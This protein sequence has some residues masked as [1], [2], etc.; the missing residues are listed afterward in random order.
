MRVSDKDMPGVSGAAR[1]A[2]VMGWPVSHS[3]SPRLHG[4]W[5]RRYGVDGAY[6][7]LAVEPRHLEQALRALPALGF[8][9]VNVTVPHKEAVLAIVD[10]ADDLARR[11]GAVN[12]VVVAEDGRLIGRNTDAFGFLENLRQQA[13]DFDP[14]AAPVLILGA[15]GAARAVAAGLLDA[16]TPEVMICNRSIG[17]AEIL[18]RA[19]D[20][21]RVSAL[22]WT[23]RGRAVATAGLIVNSTSLGMTG[24]PDLDL[25]LTMARADAVVADIV[26]TPLRTKTLRQA[27]A[28]GLTAVDGLGMLIHQARPGFAAWFG[29]DPDPEPELRAM[30]LR[31]LGEPVS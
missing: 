2:G 13:P 14:V 22:P 23:E 25:D 4:F 7:P 17:R 28:R 9:G 11:I 3:R 31:D 5:L 30:L 19:L 20:P 1:L 21:T 26:Y 16:G 18:V 6:L 27:A 10:E 12:T 29:I 8:R 24:N 15:G